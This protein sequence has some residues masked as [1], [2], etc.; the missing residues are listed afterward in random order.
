MVRKGTV[1]LFV[2]V[3]AWCRQLTFLIVSFMAG[4]MAVYD[5]A[6]LILA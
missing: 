2:N 4:E 3:I 1:S 5:G 6:F